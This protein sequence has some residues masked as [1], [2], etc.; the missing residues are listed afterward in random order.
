MD[1]RRLAGRA[2]HTHCTEFLAPGVGHKISLGIVAVHSN[3]RDSS[4]LPAFVGG[5]VSAVP[6]TKPTEY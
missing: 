1:A 2:T 4:L 5:V 6:T 3:A